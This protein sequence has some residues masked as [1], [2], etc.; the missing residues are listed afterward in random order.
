MP[1]E[2]LKEILED[3]NGLL[4]EFADKRNINFDADRLFV[5]TLFF[6]E[7]NID[8]IDLVFDKLQIKCNV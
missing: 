6:K 7:Q 3:K 8:L 1:M 2:S 4:K 5:A